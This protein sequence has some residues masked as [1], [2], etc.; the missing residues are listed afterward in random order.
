MTDLHWEMREDWPLIGGKTSHGYLWTMMMSEA[1]QNLNPFN[2]SRW[3]FT[4]AIANECQVFKGS[5]HGIDANNL[6]CLIMWSWKNWI[7]FPMQFSAVSAMPWP[8]T[9]KPSLALHQRL[10]MMQRCLWDQGFMGKLLQSASCGNWC[11]WKLIEMR[12]SCVALLMVCQKRR[13]A[14]GSGSH[15]LP[16]FSSLYPELIHC[17]NQYKGDRGRTCKTVVDGVDF[18]IPGLPL[19]EGQ[20]YV[21]RN[22]KVLPFIPK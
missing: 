8:K 21:Q 1:H 9:S 3:Q 13:S 18:V 6:L 2:A 4:M 22:G 10:A 14:N 7:A 15:V 17:A 11:S 16:V 5:H 20:E 12:L 19:K